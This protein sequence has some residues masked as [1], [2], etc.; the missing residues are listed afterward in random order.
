MVALF[1]L[2]SIIYPKSVIR[3]AI[4]VVDFVTD[5]LQAFCNLIFLMTAIRKMILQITYFQDITD[6]TTDFCTSNDR[7]GFML[8]MLFMV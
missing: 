6:L 4:F 2:L 7:F 8:F 3:T 1:A 5:W